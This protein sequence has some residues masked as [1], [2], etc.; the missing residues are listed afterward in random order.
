MK[1]G[2]GWCFREAR[3]RTRAQSKLPSKNKDKK[4]GAREL[5]SPPEFDNR[6]N[7]A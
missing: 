1:G 4:W 5:D 7:L 6:M 3:R 2:A